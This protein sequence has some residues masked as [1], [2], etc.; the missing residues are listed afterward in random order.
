[1][2]QVALGSS[3]DDYVHRI[4]RTGRAGN[5]GVA[6]SYFNQDNNGLAKKLVKVL[7]E[8]WPDARRSNSFLRIRQ[9]RLCPH[10][11]TRLPKNTEERREAED[12]VA[13]EAAV[14][15]DIEEAVP[16]MGREDTVVAVAAATV[17]AATA[18]TD[19]AADAAD[20]AAAVA[21]ATA[22]G[23]VAGA[24]RRKI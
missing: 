12:V 5:V 7:A 9:T 6:T 11:W 1:M 21:M 10:G 23:A 20:A 17:A 22:A 2:I 18:T 15:V 14:A 3:I 8:V 13:T 19:G 16:H 4:G 24:T